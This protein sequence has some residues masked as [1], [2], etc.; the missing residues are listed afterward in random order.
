MEGH[1]KVS[2]EPSP[3]QARIL[4][5]IILFIHYPNLAALLPA[6]KYLENWGKTCSHVLHSAWKL[7][8][9]WNQQNFDVHIGVN[10]HKKP[11]HTQY[12]DEIITKFRRQ[13]EKLIRSISW[14][15]VKDAKYKIQV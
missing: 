2:L 3:F 12:C 13:T 8:L 6:V 10:F 11:D 14:G 9:H 7:N 4:Y 5:F 15:K 1:N